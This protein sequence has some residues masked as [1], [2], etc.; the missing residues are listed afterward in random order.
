MKPWHGVLAALAVGGYVAWILLFPVYTSRFRLTVEV[1]TPQGL[2]SGSSVIETTIRDVKVGLPEMRGLQY[3]A[4]G[5]AVFV[6]L[7][8]GRHVIALLT[9]GATGGDQDR[10]NGLVYAALAPGRRSD[11]RE[12]A[13]LRGSG[14]LPPDSIPTLVTFADINDPK[15]ARVV[16]PQEFESVFGPGVRFKRAWIETVPAGIWPLS[17]VGITGEAVTSGLERKLPW[18]PHPRYLSGQF[19]CSPREQHCLHGGH[20]TRH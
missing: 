7:G 17:L 5:E 12:V 4:R 13:S 15:T 8:R 20:F 11:W 14:D 18:L 1:E 9:F 19:G 10:L 6:D 3:G 16:Q 2:K